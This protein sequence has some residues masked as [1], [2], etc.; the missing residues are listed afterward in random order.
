VRPGRINSLAERD[1]FVGITRYLEPLRIREVRGVPIRSSEYDEG[2]AAGRNVG[3]A[4]IGRLVRN[5]HR[6]VDGRI[7]T[8]HLL[9]RPRNQIAIVAQPLRQ[10]RVTTEHQQAVADSTR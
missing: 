4:D 8:Q 7:V 6:H 9:D 2:E 3:S 1:V 10:A 5:P